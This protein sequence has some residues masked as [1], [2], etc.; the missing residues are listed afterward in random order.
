[1]WPPTP[2]YWS[3]ILKIV[4]WAHFTNSHAVL[5]GL[6]D[7]FWKIR[8]LGQ[9]IVHWQ[10]TGNVKIWVD[11]WICWCDQIWI[12]CLLSHM[13]SWLRDETKIDLLV[14]CVNEFDLLFT[15]LDELDLLKGETGSL[16][17]VVV[18]TSS[19][20]FAS[21]LE[22]LRF[23]SKKWQLLKRG[24]HD[25]ILH[26]GYIAAPSSSPLSH[27]HLT[28]TITISPSWL[29]CSTRQTCICT[30]HIPPPGNVYFSERIS[31]HHL[32]LC[33]RNK[34]HRLRFEAAAAAKEVATIPDHHHEHADPPYL[35]W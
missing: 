8:I 19:A 26:H 12:K 20:L 9:A 15:C 34:R 29:P 10:I 30:F 33:Q 1:M 23:L 18:A 35:Y 2:S 13:G 7:F 6:R 4:L 11:C 16:A 31:R 22:K 25:N 32:D 3:I 27:H 14:T 24:S 17:S 5:K 28:I 21:N